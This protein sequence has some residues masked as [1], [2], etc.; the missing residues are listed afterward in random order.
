VWSSHRPIPHFA[1]M[2]RFPV[3]YSLF[4]K[5]KVYGIAETVCMFDDID[6]AM[7]HQLML[8]L[9]IELKCC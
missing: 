1:D 3:P 7:D 2:L 6:W 5:G 4:F 9:D 8:D